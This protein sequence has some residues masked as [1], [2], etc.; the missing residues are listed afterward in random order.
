MTTQTSD[1]EPVLI[2]QAD[3]E[4]VVHDVNS[5]FLLSIVQAAKEMYFPCSGR[6][7]DL[8]EP[9]D[10]LCFVT[11]KRPGWAHRFMKKAAGVAI[12]AGRCVKLD[13]SGYDDHTLIEKAVD[14]QV[15]PKME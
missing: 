7:A 14:E 6:V 1:T 15:R 9:L 10:A 11:F 8:D 3:T 5:E 4:V 2:L 12:K 13:P